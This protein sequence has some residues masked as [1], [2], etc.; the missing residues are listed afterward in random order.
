[1]RALAEEFG[2]PTP[3]TDEDYEREGQFEI[4]RQELEKQRQKDE[5]WARIEA[6]N[7]RKERN[8]Q[9]QLDSFVGR[10]VSKGEYSNDWHAR[11]LYS[12]VQKSNRTMPLTTSEL[13]EIE[14]RIDAANQLDNPSQLVLDMLEAIRRRRA[15]VYDDTADYSQNPFD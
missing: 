2:H 5:R 12:T 10:P 11:R 1:L 7:A 6:E 15:E 9:Q 3:I 14:E 8:L 13:A 4:E